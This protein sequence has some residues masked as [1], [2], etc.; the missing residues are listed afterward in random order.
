MPI[1][2]QGCF[3]AILL[4]VVLIDHL[5]PLPPMKQFIKMTKREQLIDFLTACLDCSDAYELEELLGDILT[6]QELVSL[7]E[8]WAIAKLLHMGFS[9]RTITLKTGSSASTIARMSNLLMHGS[10]TLY[11]A[12]QRREL[13][14]VQKE[15]EGPGYPLFCRTFP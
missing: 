9:Y 2:F 13:S 3:L 14:F 12:C 4:S 1:S 8:R 10:G 5:F 15:T 6:K 7:S 11:R